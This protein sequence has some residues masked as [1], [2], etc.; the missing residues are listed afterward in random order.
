VFPRL[1]ER[2]AQPVRTLSGGEQQ[3]LAIAR[4]LMARPSFLLLDE[5][6]LGLAP[7]MVEEIFEIIRR[8]SAEGT[9]I[10]VVEQNLNLALDIA[11]SGYV[12]DT[13]EITL[14]GSA[15]ELRQSPVV[16]SAYP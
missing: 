10:L 15:K 6:S 8:I 2:S 7:R 5:P 9:A 16:R 11:Q 12:L 3:M 13:G 14:H 4:A 1:R